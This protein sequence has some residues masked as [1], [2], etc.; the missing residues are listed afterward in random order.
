MSTLKVNSII[1]AS[2]GNTATVNSGT[3]VSTSS[4]QIA[5]AWVNFNGTGTVAI[6]AQYNVSSITD[7]ATG[8]YTVNFTNALTDANFSLAGTAGADG[9]AESIGKISPAKNVT[10][11]TT[12][13]VRFIC[14]GNGTTLYDA[15][16]VSVAIFR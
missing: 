4:S 10:N 16:P 5:K 1:D 11:F 15:T 2:G 12:T 7:N 3:P 6:R 13:S 9:A 8:D 14:T